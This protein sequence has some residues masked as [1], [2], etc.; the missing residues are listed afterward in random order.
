MGFEMGVLPFVWQSSLRKGGSQM[1]LSTVPLRWAVISST[2]V[3]KADAWG[4]AAK[5]KKWGED[6]TRQL[7]RLHKVVEDEIWEH[8][9]SV[10]ML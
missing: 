7:H 9:K 2:A 1:I 6:F 8:C 4:P 5:V 10:V 3:S